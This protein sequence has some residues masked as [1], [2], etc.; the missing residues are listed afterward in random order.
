AAEKLKKLC[1][2]ST[3]SIKARIHQ[4]H[5]STTSINYIHQ[6]HP[7][8]TSI[9]YIDRFESFNAVLRLQ[10]PKY[11]PLTP[12]SGTYS[13]FT[14]DPIKRF[15]TYLTWGLENA[16]GRKATISVFSVL[17]SA[18]CAFCLFY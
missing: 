4:L 8:T 14:S 1:L 12:S 18:Y 5:P 17:I 7:S 11:S 15:K 13:F 6:L 9:N 16:N 10:S 3:Y 2:Q